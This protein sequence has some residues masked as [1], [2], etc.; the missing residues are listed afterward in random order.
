MTKPKPTRWLS[1][2]AELRSENARLA[3]E[4]ERLRRE[5]IELRARVRHLGD[6]VYDLTGEDFG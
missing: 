3:A 5:N 1:P 2:E 4:N 6:F